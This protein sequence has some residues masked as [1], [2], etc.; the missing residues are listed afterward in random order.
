MQQ[1][2]IANLKGFKTHRLT[3]RND[4]RGYVAKTFKE[5]MVAFS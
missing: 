2:P 3:K 4:E 5:G 1:F